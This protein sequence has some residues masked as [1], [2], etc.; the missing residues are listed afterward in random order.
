M[1]SGV[2]YSMPRHS[3]GQSRTC[4]SSPS[5]TVAAVT[6]SACRC[7]SRPHQGMRAHDAYRFRTS[8]MLLIGHQ[9]RG[10][11]GGGLIGP[12]DAPL[13]GQTGHAGVA[14]MT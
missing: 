4:A 13:S 8:G 7:R 9:C 10:D 2:P 11:D 3:Q 14:G 1:P 12:K 5:V 6:D